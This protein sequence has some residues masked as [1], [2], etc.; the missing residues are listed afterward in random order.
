MTNI[1]ERNLTEAGLSKEH[2]V[3]YLHLL[4]SGLCSAKV[5]ASKTNIGRTLTYK[6][7]EQLMELELVEKNDQLGKIALFRASHPVKIKNIVDTKKQKADLASEGFSK[8]YGLLTSQYNLLAGKPNIRFL[9]GI[10]G[11]KEMYADILECGQDIKLFRSFLDHKNPEVT[12]IL[13][14]HILKQAA[15]GIKV[16]MVGPLR[17]DV[18]IDVLKQKDQE[19]MVTR[20][21]M[22]EGFLMPSQVILYANKVSITDFQ[23]L[24][25]TIIENQC[26]KDSFEKMF[27]YTFDSLPNTY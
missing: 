17:Q 24:I 8:S 13:R 14:E 20:K 16:K 23:N 12:R 6:V 1:E 9:E 2:A 15:L 11:L 4:S 27:D 21:T 3:I 18:S 5:I 19:R 22:K 10:D 26:V 7:L 25:I